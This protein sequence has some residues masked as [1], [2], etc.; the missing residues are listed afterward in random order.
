M[1]ESQCKTEGTKNPWA[2]GVEPDA[3]SVNPFATGPGP[4]GVA[5]VQSKHFLNKCLK[6][7]VVLNR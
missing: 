5:L 1:G 4:A 6:Y 2:K 3:K 7:S